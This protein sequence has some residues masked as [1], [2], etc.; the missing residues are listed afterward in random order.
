M[1]LINCYVTEVLKEP[2]EKFGKWWLIVMYDGYGKIDVTHLMFDSKE[3]AQ[4]VT[5]GYEFLS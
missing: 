3:D 4:K 1:N 5:V 2:Y